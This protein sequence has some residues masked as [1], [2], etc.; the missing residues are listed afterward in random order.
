MAS[1]LVFGVPELVPVTR[2]VTHL[3]FCA[4][5]NLNVFLVAPAINLHFVDI[6]AA[7]LFIS[8]EQEYHW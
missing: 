5:S 6:V 1:Q 8:V 4:D 3:P 7:A 2:T